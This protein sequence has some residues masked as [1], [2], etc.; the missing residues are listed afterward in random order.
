MSDT[1]QMPPGPGAAPE[2]GN[3]GETCRAC[4]AELAPDQRYCLNCGSRRADPRVDY[5]HLL[6]G[7]SNGAAPGGAPA[8]AAGAAG[9]AAAGAAAG[10]PTAASSGETRAV[11]PLGAAVAVGLLLI[12][13]LLGA[14][15][16][17]G[18]GAGDQAPVLVGAAQQAGG[19]SVSAELT[20]EWGGEDGWT[21]QISATPK[22]GADTAQL[23]QVKTDAQA[24]GASETGI[25]DSDMY[26]S[27]EPGQWVVFAGRYSSKAEATK[28][29]DSL[30]G[31]FPDAKVIE[32]SADAGAGADSGGGSGSS[33]SK[34]TN[35]ALGGLENTSPED[36]SKKSKKLP[37]T[38]GT[39]GDAPP[40]DNKAP[41]GGSGGTTIK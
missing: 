13:V 14:V 17:K 27:L 16:G 19:T 29:L 12:A 36:Y 9:G 7:N 37:D 25:I 20:D 21:I 5:Q 22:D 34:A 11:S 32:V 40:E 3:P 8:T 18:N 39:G 24:K 41:G 6:A 23:T 26:A 2:L 35:P 30:K 1:A 28:A 38:V 15:I 33:D 4:G 10:N 31:D